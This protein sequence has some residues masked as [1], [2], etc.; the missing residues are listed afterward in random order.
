[1][2]ESDHTIGVVQ[3]G[4]GVADLSISITRGR[5]GWRETILGPYSSANIE[6]DP[7]AGQQANQFQLKRWAE[8]GQAEP[9]PALPTTRPMAA[10]S[11]FAHVLI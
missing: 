10:L 11:C 7:G 4:A 3:F 8:T 9:P 5:R 6:K 1:V 2:L